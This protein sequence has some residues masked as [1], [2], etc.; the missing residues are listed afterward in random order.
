MSELTVS[1]FCWSSAR[2]V[3]WLSLTLPGILSLILPLFL[4][5][6]PYA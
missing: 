3:H 2:L 5:A 6:S 4:L 1:V